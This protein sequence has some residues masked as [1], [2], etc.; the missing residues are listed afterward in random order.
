MIVEFFREYRNKQLE[1][2]LIPPVATRMVSEQPEGFKAFLSVPPEYA[3]QNIRERLHSCKD[4]DIKRYLQ[5]VDHVE[6]AACHACTRP[7]FWKGAAEAALRELQMACLA[8]KKSTSKGIPVVAI[9]RGSGTVKKVFGSGQ[10]AAG[11]VG[12]DAANISSVVRRGAMYRG[13]IWQKL[14]DWEKRPLT[15]PRVKSNTLTT[16]D[17]IDWDELR[18]YLPEGWLPAESE[19]IGIANEMLKSW[20][21]NEL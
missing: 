16:D 11:I 6:M 9:E 13:Y 3:V 21:Q 17:G 4:D 20:E 12:C 2:R 5:Y 15:E 10:E 14:S 7:A 8:D 18:S 19:D 1:A